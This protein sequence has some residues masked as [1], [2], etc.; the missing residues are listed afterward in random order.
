MA[1]WFI[2]VVIDATGW[3]PERVPTPPPGITPFAAAD[4]HLTIAF[5][6]AIDAAR[7]ERAWRALAWPL[8]ALTVTLGEVVPMGPPRRYSALS[9]LLER[10]REQVEDAMAATRGALYAAAEVEADAR[11]AKAH[12]TLARP[13]KSAS[14]AVRRQGL[15]WARRVDVRGTE[16]TLREL[17]LFTWAD[18]RRTAQFRKAATLGLPAPSTFPTPPAEGA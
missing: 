16:L 17:A 10:G 3:Y 5:L 1:N 7:A 8:G 12:V 2:G 15:E 13:H 6:G 9:C 11:P 18:D 4:L 14:S